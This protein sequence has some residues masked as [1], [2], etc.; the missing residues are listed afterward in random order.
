ME[1]NPAVRQYLTGD[2]NQVSLCE[3]CN[4]NHSW[5]KSFTVHHKHW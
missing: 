1:W 5:L 3:S 2:F 4:E